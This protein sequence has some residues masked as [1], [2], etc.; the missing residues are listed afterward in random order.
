MIILYDDFGLVNGR[1]RPDIQGI[2]R[3]KH[4]LSTMLSYAENEREAFSAA[5]PAGA[6][7]SKAIKWQC[8]LVPV[9][10]MSRKKAK[11]LMLSMLI[12]LA[13]Q[14]TGSADL[15]RLGHDDGSAEDAVWMYNLLPI[16]GDG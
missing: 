15:V 8:L 3:Q 16:N 1:I 14:G 11:G 6:L 2:K 5:F 9:K 7:R 12:I 4:H 13:A 10:R